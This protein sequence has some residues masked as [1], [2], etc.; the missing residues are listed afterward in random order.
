M[1]QPFDGVRELSLEL[2]ANLQYLFF[3]VQHL[4]VKGGFEVR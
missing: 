2:T 4:T 1:H 3:T